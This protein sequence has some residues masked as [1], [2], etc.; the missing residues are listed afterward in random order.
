MTRLTAVLRSRV[1]RPCVASAV[2]M[3]V[4]GCSPVAEDPLPGDTVPTGPTNAPQHMDAPYVVLVSFDGF[5]YDYQDMYP[6]PAFDRVAAAGVRAE[7]MIPI[8]PSKTFP[9]HYSIAT[10]MYA[11]NHGLVGNRFWA[12]DKNALY[13]MSNRTVVEDGTWYRG[14][15]IWVTAERQG[16]VSA[17]YFFVGSEADV[18]GVRPSY[19]HR[20]DD[21]VPNNDRVDAVLDWLE[22]PAEKR[23]HMIT[24]YFS[25]VD[26]AGHGFGP[27]SDEVGAAIATVDGNLGRLLDGIEQLAHADDVYV[28][29]V[30]DH[31]MLIA[32]ADKADVVDPSLFPGVRFIE[33]GPYGSIFVDEGGAERAVQ[34]R[35][36]LQDMLPEHGVYLRADVP[37]RLHYSADPRIGDIVI[38][39]PRERTIVTPDR[40]PQSDAYTHGWD[41]EVDEMG[42]M[43]LA[44]GPGIAGGRSI[45]AFESVHVYPFIA[46]LLGLRANPEA[47][48]RLA[49]LLPLL[50]G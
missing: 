24:L 10:G 20:F 44:M 37:E 16:M 50:G 31:G 18:G 32:P 12:P 33:L 36:S 47:D 4:T 39:A 8:F 25:D 15:P 14:E 21:T 22:L 28:V 9:T 49:V 6:T 30:S 45:D 1:L 11:E 40:V 48:G 46:H 13:T 41:P 5:R 3:I 35:D 29:L 34:L 19:W 17:S 7:R 2:V 43:F 23:P 26:G 38:V 42:A 27:G